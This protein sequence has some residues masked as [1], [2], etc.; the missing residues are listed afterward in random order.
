MRL[1]RAVDSIGDN[2]GA[3]HVRPS[4]LAMQIAGCRMPPTIELATNNMECDL[5]SD[6]AVMKD[7]DAAGAKLKGANKQTNT[8]TKSGRATTFADR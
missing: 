6:L 1:A 7:V 8:Q 2:I 4:R 5:A 3:E